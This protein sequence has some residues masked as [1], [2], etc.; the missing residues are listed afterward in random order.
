MQP[1]DYLSNLPDGIPIACNLSTISGK[2]IKT[3]GK[4]FAAD[5]PEL[6][7]CFKPDAFPDGESPDI[8]SD[9]LVFIETGEVVTLICSILET[10]AAGNKLRVSAKELV[11]KSERR[12]YFRVSADRLTVFFRQKVRKGEKIP[13]MCKARGVNISC[14]GILMKTDRQLKKKERIMM[15][16]NFPEPLNKNIFCEGSVVRV[17]KSKNGFYV[18]LKFDKLDPEISDEIGRAHV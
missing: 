4:L 13:K 11:Q 2:Q 9:C 16:L 17:D 7:I 10:P 15:R 18:G 1:V 6:E 12:E 5:P 8:K 14:A 3:S